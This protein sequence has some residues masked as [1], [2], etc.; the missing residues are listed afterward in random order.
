MFVLDEGRQSAYANRDDADDEQNDPFS[1]RYQITEVDGNDE[2]APLLGCYSISDTESAPEHDPKG[3]TTAL[4]PASEIIPSTPSPPRRKIS[5]KIS[6]KLVTRPSFLNTRE[7]IKRI[8]AEIRRRRN[9][10]KSRKKAKAKAT[11]SPPFVPRNKLEKVLGEPLPGGYESHR[12]R[13]V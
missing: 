1:D 8:A 6:V 12:P 4:Y 13:Y 10:S 7:S 11:A 5:K 9:K 2:G 3:S